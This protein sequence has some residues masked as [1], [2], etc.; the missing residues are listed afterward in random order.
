MVW[1]AVSKNEFGTCFLENENVIGEV[2]K[3][4]LQYYAFSK[5]LKY[6]QDIIFQQNGT[7]PHFPVLVRQYL[8]QTL[9]RRSDLKRWS[10]FMAYS[11]TGLD[12]L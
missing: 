4:I 9:P 11:L 5:L 12:A 3:R 10:H 6:L 2:H 7:P 8:G 1:C